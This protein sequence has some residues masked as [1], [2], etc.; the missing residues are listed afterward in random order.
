MLGL[1]YALALTCPAL[2]PNPFTTP[3]HHKEAADLEGES[4]VPGFPT[5]PARVTREYG[6][7]FMLAEI[8][9]PNE[10]RM[11]H[12]F[13]HPDMGLAVITF[14]PRY[15]SP[16]LVE[17]TR[18]LARSGN[19]THQAG[20]T[21]GLISLLDTALETRVFVR[22]LLGASAPAL[23][24]RAAE[25]LCWCG[26]PE[27]YPYL[28]KQSGAERDVHARAAMVEAAAAI[29]HR[30][31][32][33]GAGAATTLAPAASPA[34]TYQQFAEVLGM[35]PTASTRLAVIERLRHT[36]VAE[37]ITMYSD[38]L[39]HG[40]R[41][42]ALLKVHRLLVGYPASAGA[43][44][45][46]GAAPAAAPSVVRSLI[47]PVRDYIDAGRKSYG[48]AVAPGGSFGGKIHVGDDVAWRLD[49][50][51]VV[52][53]GDGIVR[54]VDLGR[55]SW[56][57]LVVVEH[58]DA[59]GGRFCSLYGHL[60]P[61]VCVVPGEVVRQGQK[62]GVVGPSYSHANGGYLAHLHF[63]IHR[64]AFLLPDR[65]GEVVAL[66][67]QTTTATV[68]AV[69]EE[70]VEVRLTDG[71]TR[72]MERSDDW[73]CGYLAPSEF[74]TKTHGWVEPQEFIRRLKH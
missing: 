49:H 61:L 50:E 44:A 19:P 17:P 71:T 59:K 40:E 53:I 74:A 39:E 63:G 20:A 38:R 32:I 37:P 7:A 48:T 73:T 21:G 47:G 25:Y 42:A 51:T 46:P 60:G 36:E 11:L 30:A 3:R 41:G 22:G 72:S 33:F 31:A 68:T 66:P 35:R 67:E 62:L 69:H 26:C 54:S 57:G 70:S 65:V 1:A 18:K 27:D 5:T 24:G 13:K 29:K 4:H 64:G 2:P 8:D 16:R 45:R 28:T 15:F 55:K 43:P 34:A 14:L 23:R 12:A 6:D 58:V 56:G 9:A 10:E 52:A